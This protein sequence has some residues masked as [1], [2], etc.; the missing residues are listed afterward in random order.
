MAG[1]GIGRK[2]DTD[3]RISKTKK[4]R[5]AASLVLSSLYLSPRSR[6][7]R[8]RDAASYTPRERPGKRM[9]A[10]AFAGVSIIKDRPSF[11][12]DLIIHDLRG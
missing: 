4:A 6:L 2:S 8:N 11:A 1:A 5:I 3:A 7:S 10:A 9:G 12:K